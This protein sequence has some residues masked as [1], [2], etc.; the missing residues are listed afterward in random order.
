MKIA[1]ISLTMNDYHSIGQWVG[2]YAQYA[3]VIYKHI[4]VDNNSNPD[5]KQLL[6]ENFPNSILILRTSNG[7]TTGA[8]N[9]GIKEA[10]KD[11]KVDSIMLIANDIK[12]SG[13]DIRALYGLLFNGD[14]HIGA[15]AP[16]LLEKD[17]ETIMTYGEK[18]DKD[19]GL[20]R[21]YHF[22]KLSPKLPDIVESECLPGGMN[23]IRREVYEKVGLQDESLFM[24]M[25]ENDFFYRMAQHRYRILATKNA[26]ALH[27]HIH[28]ER[29]RHND[30]SL[31]FFYINR[32]HLLVCKRYRSLG[33]TLKLF[34]VKFFWS[35]IKYSYIFIKDHTYKKIFYYYLGLLVG[36][37]GYKT[38][39]IQKK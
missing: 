9:V 20:N 23:L 3:S 26:V 6:K 22:E 7:G 36:I 21:L 4:I 27:C 37:M 8:Y 14:A 33:T 5:Y 24:Y 11:S 34:F 31:A 35:G 13:K 32:N 12:I 19:M 28:T 10:L 30:N 15:V 2:F 16:V 1:A 18:L 39:F 38:N 17:G 25:D 29:G